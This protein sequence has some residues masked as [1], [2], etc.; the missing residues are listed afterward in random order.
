MFTTQESFSNFD[1]H[2][3]LNFIFENG[4]KIDE[5][6]LQSKATNYENQSDYL[7]LTL[8]TWK[9]SNSMAVRVLITFL[10]FF[11]LKITRD[12]TDKHQHF[13]K[14]KKF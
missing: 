11:Y 3:Q 12:T 10:S 8:T 4:W 7:L 2:K 6:Y 14:E 9:G 5:P 13:T 1:E